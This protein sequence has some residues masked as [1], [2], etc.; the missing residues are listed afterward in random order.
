MEVQAEDALAAKGIVSLG[1]VRSMQVLP[2]F[3]MIPQSS[4]LRIEVGN[5]QYD[6]LPA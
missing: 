6:V 2:I 1:R 4:A 5:L 3:I